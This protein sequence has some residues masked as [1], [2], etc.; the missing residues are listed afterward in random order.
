MAGFDHHK[1]NQPDAKLCPV[2]HHGTVADNT[3]GFERL[4]AT[5]AGVLRQP[6]TVAECTLG[7]GRVALKLFKYV[8]VYLIEFYFY[9]SII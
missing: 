3:A 6:D 7:L 1:N 9:C 5:P 8:I 2:Q 4:E